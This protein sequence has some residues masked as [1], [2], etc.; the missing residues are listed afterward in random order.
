MKDKE[1]A[2]DLATDNHDEASKQI[3]DLKK[4]VEESEAELKTAQEKYEKELSEIGQNAS[5]AQQAEL[6]H[7]KEKIT[8]LENDA[9]DKD[10]QLKLTEDT[11]N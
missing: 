8:E 9:E 10:R 3:E 5:N 7:L 4:K 6:D 2:L 11:V 1:K